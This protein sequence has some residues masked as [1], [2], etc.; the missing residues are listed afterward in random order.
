MEP[1]SKH[2]GRQ[3]ITKAPKF[4]LF[5][6]G[7]AS[8]IA[9]RNIT[10][11]TGYDFGRAFEH[12]ILMEIIAYRS[13]SGKDFAINY[14]R[15]KTGLEVDFILDHGHTAI[16]V[17]AGRTVHNSDLRPLD[18]FIEEYSPKQSYVVCN[19]SAPRVVD[20][21]H[22]VPWRRFLANLWEGEII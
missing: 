4:Y 12:F 14:W 8:Y 17:K 11:E 16:E 6:V 21:I 18:A 15:T 7:V 1:F 13:Y 19:E 3:I 5:D 10:A 20:K 22:I 9:G 2:G